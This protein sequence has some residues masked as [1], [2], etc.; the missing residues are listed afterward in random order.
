MI[1]SQKLPFQ[2]S[3]FY[4]RLSPRLKNKLVDECLKDNMET[5]KY[6][7]N[8]VQMNVHADPIFIRK[9]VTSL[10]FEIYLPGSTIVAAG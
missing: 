8:D 9:I 3:P 6:F 10:E 7:F 1:H 5:F 4:K 2:D